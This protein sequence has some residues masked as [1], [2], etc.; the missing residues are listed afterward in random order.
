MA[1]I[2]DPNVNLVN[3]TVKV[4]TSSS[5]L[6][7]VKPNDNS[8]KS[9]T[10]Q[11]NDNSNKLQTTAHSA[12]R[13]TE[14]VK[15][16]TRP[17]ESVKPTNNFMKRIIVIKNGEFINPLSTEE[18]L[19]KVSRKS[20]KQKRQEHYEEYKNKLQEI[21]NANKLLLFTKKELM[22]YFPKNFSR[23]DVL[24]HARKQWN[25]S[26]NREELEHFFKSRDEYINFRFLEYEFSCEENEDEV[27]NYAMNDWDDKLIGSRLKQVFKYKLSYVGF[28]LREYNKECHQ[29]DSEDD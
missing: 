21:K 19:V 2:C 8:I 7:E 11:S 23:T 9:I 5:N 18:S 1:C 25:V 28:R 16:T 10:R 6:N 3:K 27:I 26:N 12:I 4:L 14:S 20:W 24:F 17:T 13:P 15:V 22:G 29:D